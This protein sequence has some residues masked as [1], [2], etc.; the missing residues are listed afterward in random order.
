M[1]DKGNRLTD[2]DPREIYIFVEFARCDSA[3]W[4]RH[5]RGPENIEVENSTIQSDA[6][7]FKG[8][9]QDAGGAP[10]ERSSVEDRQE[11]DGGDC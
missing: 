9:D 7:E 11:V 3:L 4:R 5:V 8:H 10:G 2:R 1:V 6:E